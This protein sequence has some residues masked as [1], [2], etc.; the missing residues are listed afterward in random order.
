MKNIFLITAIVLFFLSLLISI[1]YGE[2]GNKT[3]KK[4]KIIVSGYA[5]SCKKALEDAKSKCVNSHKGRVTFEGLCTERKDVPEDERYKKDIY[6]EV[7][8]KI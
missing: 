8:C 7:E 2:S 1:S 3:V 6:C 4:C 5:N